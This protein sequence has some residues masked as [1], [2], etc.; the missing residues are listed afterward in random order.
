MHVRTA[1]QPATED[2][3]FRIAFAAATEC[4]PVVRFGRQSTKIVL[5]AWTLGRFRRL[6]TGVLAL[7]VLWP[8]LSFGQTTGEKAGHGAL[9]AEVPFVGC[10]G[11]G[12]SESY[13]PQIGRAHV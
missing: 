11:Y 6:C 10:P 5:L 9:L 12:Q 2:C 13:R 8:P 4:G 3:G 1:N 7:T